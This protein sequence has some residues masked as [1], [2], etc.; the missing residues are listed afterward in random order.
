MVYIRRATTT[1]VMAL[2]ASGCIPASGTVSYDITSPDATIVTVALSPDITDAVLQRP[3]SID[4]LREPRDVLSDTLARS[5]QD[6]G[7]CSALQT[8]GEVETYS[9][10]TSVVCVATGQGL[11]GESFS[12]DLEL[13]V[14]ALWDMRRVVAAS[15][16]EV[17]SEGYA[18]FPEIGY[19]LPDPELEPFRSECSEGSEEACML[20]YAASPEGSYDEVFAM[21]ELR[22]DLQGRAP[23]WWG[24]Q[25]SIRVEVS[26]RHP[27][28]LAE[29]N[30]DSDG[31]GEVTWV[32]A[33]ESSGEY[34][35][36]LR[37]SWVPEPSADEV[38][39]ADGPDIRRF[40]PLLLLAGIVAG[41]IAVRARIIAAAQ[42]ILKPG[43]RKV[44]YRSLSKSSP[45]RK[46]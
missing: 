35:R 23:D 34:R 9:T 26:V 24:S 20:L 21:V 2:A 14:S 36:G 10:D 31:S 3:R 27:G 43:P 7:L 15:A 30:G 17:I 45:R 40:A 28:Q 39:E 12:P 13:E 19:S 41:V 25:H 1:A 5:A 16:I 29:H 8:L 46:K 44:K 33:S 38:S 32:F 6:P 4:D 11:E 42:S 22:P 37:V 18:S